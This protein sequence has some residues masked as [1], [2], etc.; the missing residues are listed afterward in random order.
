MASVPVTRPQLPSCGS[1]V[2]AVNVYRFH[3]E[4]LTYNIHIRGRPFSFS[5]PHLSLSPVPE[6]IEG[7]GHLVDRQGHCIVQARVCR[8][9][10]KSI[11]Q[12]YPV[13]RY[14]IQRPSMSTKRYTQ[15][16]ILVEND[17]AYEA[18]LDSADGNVSLCFSFSDS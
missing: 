15:I 2:R 13:R 12:L 8:P 10:S 6:P 3:T 7:D 18:V 4:V 11:S 9:K 5:W 1:L 14:A 17:Y 16:E